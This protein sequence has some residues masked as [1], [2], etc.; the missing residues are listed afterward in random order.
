MF[1]SET[2]AALQ[3]VNSFFP[4][5]FGLGAGISTLHKTVSFNFGWFII[6]FTDIYTTCYLQAFA[7]MPFFDNRNFIFFNY[8]AL[9]Y[10]FKPDAVLNEFYYKNY[11]PKS[12]IMDKYI[13]QLSYGRQNYRKYKTL[14][15]IP[16]SLFVFS[17]SLL[18]H[19]IKYDALMDGRADY[20]MENFFSREYLGYELMMEYHF[21]IHPRF[22]P[23][24][25]FEHGGEAG[26]G[27][28]D[29]ER[30]YPGRTPSGSLQGIISSDSG[31]FVS[32]AQIGLDWNFFS[33]KSL[34][35]PGFYL[36]RL[37]ARLLG[38]S[39]YF[40]DTLLSINPKKFLG[41]AGLSVSARGNV[42]Y[43]Y[44][45]VFSATLEYRLHRIAVHR[46]DP[47]NFNFNANFSF[48]F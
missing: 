28:P 20:L 36:R 43:T 1:L 2:D 10:Y 25:F 31:E 48:G 45:L 7:E 39:G 17:T 4:F 29:F 35:A 44:P 38:E 8:Y 37:D 12:A 33:G 5:S 9:R 21:N 22:S 32:C 15:E 27:I 42:F 19:H 13:W 18:L 34:G 24:V 16:A 26:D 11:T 40:S 23:Y 6:S 46:Y 41:K 47:E 14:G 3:Y 30:F